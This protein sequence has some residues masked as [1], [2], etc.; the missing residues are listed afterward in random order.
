MKVDNGFLQQIKFK[1]R[2]KVHFKLPSLEN[3]CFQHRKILCLHVEI[4][5]NSL[6]PFG[7]FLMLIFFRIAVG[8]VSFSGHNFLKR[9]AW[10]SRSE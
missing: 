5:Q 3:S 4:V 10:L 2:H 9:D 1:I 8:M 6:P 7:F